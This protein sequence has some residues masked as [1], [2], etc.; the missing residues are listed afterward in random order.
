YYVRSTPS[1]GWELLYIMIDETCWYP[2]ERKLHEAAFSGADSRELGRPVS[3]PVTPGE[4]ERAKEALKLLRTDLNMRQVLATLG[5]SRC[6]GH[7]LIG[8]GSLSL[9]VHGDLGNGHKLDMIYDRVMP[10][11]SPSGW[12]L[13]WVG[14]D[15]QDN[16]TGLGHWEAADRV[17]K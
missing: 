9:S 13:S 3:P 11:Y 14:I 15:W 7:F 5:L 10:P 12:K 17:R 1:A 2:A 16:Q 8:S 6:R 4:L